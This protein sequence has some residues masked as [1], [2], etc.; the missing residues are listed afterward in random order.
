M[1]A[2]IATFEGGNVDELRR[3]AERMAADGLP[4]DAD[5]IFG[6]LPEDSPPGRPHLAQALVA[7]VFFSIAMYGA[8]KIKERV[9][10]KGD[11]VGRFRDQRSILHQP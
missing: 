8:A 5:E 4:I 9:V 2:R 3:M 6:L 11:H 7:Y 1:F 10:L